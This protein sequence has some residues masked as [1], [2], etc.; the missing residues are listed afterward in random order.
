[1]NNLSDKILWE[2]CLESKNEA[3]EQLYRRYYP[4][5]YAYGCKMTTDKD[6]VQ[7]II[8]DLFVKIMTDYKRLPHLDNVNA[9][10]FLAFRRRLFAANKNKQ[11][12]FIDDLSDLPDI[13]DINDEAHILDKKI[14]KMYKAYKK[15]SAKQKK[16]IYLYYICKMGHDDI[17]HLLGIN[18][19]SSKNM[20]HRSL[21]KL[22]TLF[23][24]EIR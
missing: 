17:S 11:I 6:I 7:N 23:F 1:M 19:Q 21:V 18:N 3:F 10:L 20:L 24:L 9:Y 2:N 13:S 8:Q 4:R 16:I 5:L 12:L 15:L 22:R 14:N